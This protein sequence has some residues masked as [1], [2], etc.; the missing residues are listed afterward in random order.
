MIRARRQF[1]D[2]DEIVIKDRDHEFVQ[3][4]DRHPGCRISWTSL[5]AAS[6]R[7][8]FNSSNRSRP[9][10]SRAVSSLRA[11]LR[12][13][14]QPVQFARASVF[15]FVKV[16]RQIVNPRAE[17]FQ[18]FAAA[19]QILFERV[20]PFV[21]PARQH[22][23]GT[24]RDERHMH[25]DFRGLPDAVEPPDPLFQQFRIERQIEQDQVMGELEVPAFTADLRT[26]QN[27]RPIFLRE[28]RRVAIAL[29]QRKPFVKHRLLHVQPLAQRRVNR[30]NL[31]LACGR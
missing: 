11:V 8:E 31:A 29:H 15:G 25:L 21:I 2:V 24:A 20:Q 9:C 18:Q 6:G 22:F 12:F 28:P 27:A 5:A 23:L 30:L 1:F 4:S 17:P 26:D 14:N 13:G 10:S 16:L 7:N 19:V 3:R